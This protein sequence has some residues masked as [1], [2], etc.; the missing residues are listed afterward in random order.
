MSN[1]H[2][3]EWT[4]GAFGLEPNWTKDPD[5]NVISQITRKQLN[6]SHDVPI[7]VALHSKGSFTKLYKI[8]T[9]DRAYSMRVSLPVDPAH[10][11]ESAV[12]T[13]E[14]VGRT[15]SI[16]QSEIIAYSSDNSNELGFEW[17]LTDHVPG[18][19]LYKAWRSLSWDAKEG[20]VKQLAE[21]QAKMSEH[22]FQ[23]IGNL[24]R[25]NDGFAVDR[26]VSTIS[27]QGDHVT[28]NA[29]RG[30]FTSSHEWLKARLQ[31]VLAEQ[32]QIVDTSCDEDEIEDAEFARDLAKQLSELLPTVFLPNSGA[33]EP[34]VLVHG[35]L[36][37][38]N[39][40][41]D[42]SGKIAIMDWESVSAVPLW[43]AYQLPKLFEEWVR[44][45]KPEKEHYPP[46]S[47]EED[48]NDDDGLDNEG[49]TDL[50]WDHLLEYEL[51]QLRKVFVEETETRNPGWSV[52]SKESTL[53][54][55]FERAVEECANG[56]RN[57][58]VKRWV[59]TL[60]GGEPG[61][62][63]AMLFSGPEDDQV[64]QTSM[65]WEEA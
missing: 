48:D 35:S 11:T 26:L 53:K 28:S 1:Q 23:K 30:P 60:A 6:I 58:S 3:L 45:E 16:P 41:V 29:V 43:R 22:K 25:Q 52:S 61:D 21:Y 62:L 54:N 4:E 24:Y 39:I 15:T 17:M 12:A 42:G 56:W 44:E 9:P 14:F 7:E 33:S 13:M 59:D 19:V 18:T 38:H 55:D 63:T 64:S 47:D 32:Q 49:I 20:I 57:K 36:S 34:T 27:Y 10:R 2:G 31:R 46:D 50:Y 37:M 40:T 8:S 65:D 5:T 51:T